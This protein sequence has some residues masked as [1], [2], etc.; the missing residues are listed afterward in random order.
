[1]RPT[2]KKGRA[3]PSAG[4]R[5]G[6]LVSFPDYPGERLRLRLLRGDPEAAPDLV[7]TLRIE[8]RPEVGRVERPDEFRMREHL[9]P[10]RLD[11]V[12]DAARSTDE[13]MHVHERHVALTRRQSEPGDFEIGFVDEI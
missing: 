8:A 5:L 7:E 11:V 4:L 9:E 2:A 3:E 1:M 10:M 12:L 13:V 6:F